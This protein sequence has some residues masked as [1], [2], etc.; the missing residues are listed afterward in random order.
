MI[1]MS[2][3]FAEKRYKI[4]YNMRRLLP[5]FIMAIVMVLFKVFFPYPNLFT[6]LIINSGFI[7]LFILYAQY[8]DQLITVFF[9]RSK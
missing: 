6:E 7:I 8:R 3:I 5:Y 9:K 1:I 4:N 2:F